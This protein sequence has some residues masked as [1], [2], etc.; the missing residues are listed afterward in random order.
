MEMKVRV[1]K[2]TMMKDTCYHYT[3]AEDGGI[4]G[5]CYEIILHMIGMNFCLSCGLCGKRNFMTLSQLRIAT[6]ACEFD[7]NGIGYITL[8]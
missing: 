5:L 4:V 1:R 8:T 7:D 3:C 2:D 6:L